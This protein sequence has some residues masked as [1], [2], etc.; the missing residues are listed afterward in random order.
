MNIWASAHELNVHEHLTQ[1]R[2]GT[3]CGKRSRFKN[4]RLGVKNRSYKYTSL[5]ER[6]YKY[7]LILARVGKVRNFP[8]VKKLFF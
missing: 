7:K 5:Y 1:Q 3:N 8:K 4:E 2:F 6:L